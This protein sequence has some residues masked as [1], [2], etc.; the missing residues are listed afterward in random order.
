MRLTG[1]AVIRR[2]GQRR[3]VGAGGLCAAVGL[4]LVTAAPAGWASLA[5]HA[6]VGA[7]CANLVPVMFSLAGRQRAMPE[8]LALPAVTTM[9]YAGILA[10]PALIGFVSGASSLAVAFIGLAVLLVLAGTGGA[11]LRDEAGPDQGRP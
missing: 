1:D 8:S 6:L 5:G 10:G 4:L 9:G 3:V 11:R 7:G 2:L